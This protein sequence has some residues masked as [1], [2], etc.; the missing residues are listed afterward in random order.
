MYYS[1]Y[2]PYYVQYAYPTQDRIIFPPIGGGGTTPSF[3]PIGG[4]GFPSFP[5]GPQGGPPSSPPFGG[6]DMGG[7]DQGPPTSPP[8]SFTPQLS[9][10]NVSTFAVDAGSMRPCL[11]RFTYVWLNNGNA[12]W[13]Y[14]TFVGRN[15]VAGFRWRRNRWTYYGTDTNRIRSF[16]C[17]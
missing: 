13:F 16:Q 12:F 17:N 4:G 5:G 1:S 10:S 11:Y 3:P 2:N 6:P 15:S 7:A 8:P 14:P 9:Q